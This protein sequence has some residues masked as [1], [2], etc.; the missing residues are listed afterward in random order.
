MNWKARQGLGRPWPAAAYWRK[1][2]LTFMLKSVK[3]SKTAAGGDPPWP[4]AALDMRMEAAA[5]GIA[6]SCDVLKR[7]AGK[8]D[9]RGCL[10]GRPRA[11]FGQ[12]PLLG[13]CGREFGKES[14]E[15]WLL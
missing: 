9:A 7:F 15:K 8:A 2:P 3:L 5:I 4:I 1:K 13:G 11:F 6:A 12:V 10:S 14:D